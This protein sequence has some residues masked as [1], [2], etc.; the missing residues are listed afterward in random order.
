MKWDTISLNNI[1][2]FIVIRFFLYD[3]H[4]Y[5]R[6]FLHLKHVSMLIFNVA[7]GVKQRNIDKLVI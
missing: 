3:P 4:Y 2:C 5:F 6:F 1:I 7:R